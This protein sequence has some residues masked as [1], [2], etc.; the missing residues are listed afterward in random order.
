MT[1]IEKSTQEA[2]RS[3]EEIRVA[4]STEVPLVALVHD[5]GFPMTQNAWA[6]GFL[7]IEQVQRVIDQLQYDLDL[8]KM[9]RAPANNPDEILAGPRGPEL[10]E[11][12]EILSAPMEQ[13]RFSYSNT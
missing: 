5:R 8:I 6:R 12:D 11:I 9:I 13:H 3:R 7:M 2:L 4:K 10:I 1:T